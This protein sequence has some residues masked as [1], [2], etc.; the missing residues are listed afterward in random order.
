MTESTARPQW[1][2][3]GQWWWDGHRWVAAAPPAYGNPYGTPYGTGPYGAYPAYG[4][5]PPKS[6]DGKAIASLVCSLVACG[7]GSIAGVVLGHMS[8]SE[9]RRENREPSGLALAGLIIGYL[10]I[11]VAAVALIG[12]LTAFGTGVALHQIDP[13]DGPEPSG[14][15]AVALHSAGDAEEGYLDD[16]S[17][18]ASSMTD[19]YPYGYEDTDGVTVEIAWIQ[20][21]TYCLKATDADQT[22]WLS[23]SEPDVVSLFPCEGP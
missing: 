6:T 19:L 17:V 11:A 22:L 7:I 5:P 21:E 2:P 13:F 3:D 1:S 9:A 4:A 23:T 20:G 15:A 8:R 12:L 18:Y 10:G 16:H 14:P